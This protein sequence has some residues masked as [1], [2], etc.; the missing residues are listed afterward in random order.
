MKKRI[1]I[2]FTIC[3]CHSTHSQV[4]LQK[5]TDE[6]LA[7]KGL[8]LYKSHKYIEALPYLYAYYQNNYE[9][10]K[11]SKSSIE[12]CLQFIE[13]DIV[14]QTDKDKL[15]LLELQRKLEKCEK[16][17]GPWAKIQ[18]L[19]QS[20]PELTLLPPNIVR[21]A[22]YGTQIETSPNPKAKVSNAP[23]ASSRYNISGTINVKKEGQVIYD[24]EKDTKG[25]YTVA[26]SRLSL[27]YDGSYLKYDIDLTINFPGCSW[28]NAQIVLWF[29]DDHAACI[30]ETTADNQ[31]VSRTGRIAIPKSLAAQNPLDIYLITALGN[32]CSD[33]IKWN[34][35]C[36]AGQVVV[37]TIPR[38]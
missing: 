6:M 27:V 23:K 37:G 1:L 29:D 20:G 8:T 7:D 26:W 5:L 12:K 4:V 9:A 16:P 33:V 18:G 22:Q 35:C 15:N 10:L 31:S 21:E 3:L 30:S 13:V 19:E 11:R 17:N 24:A 2:F 38:Q 34:G 14:Q 25:L 36:H 28:C 32:N